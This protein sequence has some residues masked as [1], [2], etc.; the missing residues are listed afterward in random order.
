MRKRAWAL[1]QP[2]VMF[3][4]KFLNSKVKTARGHNG[5]IGDL[6]MPHVAMT[7]LRKPLAPGD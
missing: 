3:G 2:E 7:G 5:L 1:A 4:D 6:A